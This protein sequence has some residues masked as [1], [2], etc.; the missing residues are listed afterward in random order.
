MK[1]LT[2]VTLGASKPAEERASAATPAIATTLGR[3][4]RSV[5]VE[6]LIDAR[7]VAELLGLS[8][9][10]SVFGYLKRYPDMPRPVVDRGPN[11]ARLWVRGDVE[12]WAK[13]RGSAK[14]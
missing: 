5:D 8:H 6:D 14:R 11:R 1:W 4:R 7:D 13:Q 2:L 10:N 9:P 3:M 12:A